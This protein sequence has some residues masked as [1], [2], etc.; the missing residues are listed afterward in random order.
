MKNIINKISP[1]LISSVLVFFLYQQQLWPFDVYSLE[2]STQA[3]TSRCEGIV[4][5]LNK[6]HT[7][8]Q[9]WV[10]KSEKI[11][12]REIKNAEIVFKHIQGIE[13]EDH[14]SISLYL[15]YDKQ[16]EENFLKNFN[17]YIKSKNIDF[18]EG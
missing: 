8:G 12:W 4:N 3:E 13:D 9:G 18:S 16:L 2:V 5:R 7:P 1:I 14:Y 15:N 6:L 11:L 10:S 17:E